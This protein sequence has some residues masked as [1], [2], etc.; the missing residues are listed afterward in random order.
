MGGLEGIDKEGWELGEVKEKE[1]K[2]VKEKK[3]RGEHQRGLTRSSL[4]T[5]ERGPFDGFGWLTAGKLRDRSSPQIM[6]IQRDK[7]QKE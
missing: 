3:A 5:K 7:Q 6:G 2:R 1:R 4:W